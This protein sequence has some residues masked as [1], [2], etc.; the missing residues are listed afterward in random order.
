MKR[1][2]F[3]RTSCVACLSA[4]GLPALLPSCKSV[5]FITGKLNNDGLLIDPNDFKLKKTGKSSFR[6]YIIV[7]NEALTYPICIYR[8]G[9]TEYSAVWMQCTHQG[10]ELQAAGDYLHCPAHGSEFTNKGLVL[11]GPADRNLR[12]F[13]VTIVNNELFVDLRKQ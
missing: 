12:S 11:N 2:E 7:R 13:P 6:S 10:T 4:V 3:I 9:D 8:F 5:K 1:R